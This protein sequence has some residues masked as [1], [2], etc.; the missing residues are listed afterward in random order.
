LARFVVESTVAMK[1]FIPEIHSSD[2][3]RLLEG[4]HELL[5]TDML[6]PESSDLISRK[7]RLG[8]LTLEDCREVFTAVQS[9]PVSTYPSQNLLE[10]ALEI[11][12]GLDRPLSD[13]L[14]LALAVQQDCRLVT[15]KKG[16]FDL[17]QGTPFSV[18]V[19]WV[20]DVR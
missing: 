15:A 10:G 17:L 1:W 7:A 13:G 6:L 19:K 20:G 16:L 4:R 9:V 5:A 11:T 2:A 12:V 3:A 18:H 14:N 8:E